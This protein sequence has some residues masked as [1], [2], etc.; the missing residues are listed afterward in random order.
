VSIG[1]AC[2]APTAFAQFNDVPAAAPAG[3][4]YSTREADP[5]GRVGRLA[6]VIG[7][8]WQFNPGRGEWLAAER[9]LPVT[10][11]DRLS[12]DPGARAEVRIG[13][14]L[15]RMDSRTE[16]EV[17]R[18][19]DERFELRLHKG[20]ALV[21]LQ[22]R[23]LAAQFSLLTDE[24]R[25]RT[26]R[27]GSYRFD[28][29]DARTQVT[30][31]RGSMDFV[32]RDQVMTVREGQRIE[33]VVAST[34]R[35][36]YA[37]LGAARDAFAAW[38][39]ER[40]RMERDA[41]DRVSDSSYV[42]PEMTG[43]EDLD[44]HGRWE[45]DPELGPVWIPLN[46]AVD[47]APYTV[48]RWVWVSPWGWTWVDQAP[49]GFAPFHYGRWVQRYSRWCWTPGSYVARP[50]YSP[51]LVNWSEPPPVYRPGVSISLNIFSGSGVR[52]SPLAPREPY[53]PAYI[54]S[55]RHIRE[56]N[57]AWF[58]GGGHA[59]HRDRDGW[60]R[61]GGDSDRRGGRDGREGSRVISTVPAPGGVQGFPDRPGFRPP[62][63]L[64]P[65]SMGGA[66]RGRDM[67][68]SGERDRDRDRDRNSP[69][70]RMN[71]GDRGATD[72]RRGDRRDERPVERTTRPVA[73]EPLGAVPRA[74]QG[75][76]TDSPGP[77]PTVPAPRAAVVLTAPRSMSNPWLT[78][79]REDM[80]AREGGQP[81][82]R[83]SAQPRD[84]SE[85]NDRN[86]RNER[87][88]FRGREPG[89]GGH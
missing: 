61:D 76:R 20:A 62:N 71:E 52:W 65:S 11:G 21:R 48:G 36:Q 73:A 66:D 25:F 12:T 89:S 14:T 63:N 60:L 40:D 68:R 88:D 81:N 18:L 38:S 15:L 10:T 51:A 70:A 16:V 72:N 34:G 8:V 58:S 37:E 83:A 46:V 39:S 55:P 27:A 30:A 80:R 6:E 23:E 4:V 47:W 31:I 49:W 56:V 57:E 42:S 75:S 87:R 22:D 53:R 78:P 17:L 41:A 24:G 9:N 2:T 29:A 13:S 86:D 45:Q 43:A 35:A 1:V 59:S 3:G 19:D 26:P 5:P 50:V 84:R 32:D 82:D 7:Q 77:A 54:S 67:D 69:P 33:F 79:S 85:G 28:R 74:S 64:P 44:R